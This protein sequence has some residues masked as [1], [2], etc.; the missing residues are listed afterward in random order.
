MAHSVRPPRR[1]LMVVNR[2]PGAVGQRVIALGRI[3]PAHC[4]NCAD[5]RTVAVRR[6]DGEL[7]VTHCP[8]CSLAAVDIVAV[9]R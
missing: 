9:T 8:V 3:R 5:F 6:P 2:K 1:H 7:S 4:S